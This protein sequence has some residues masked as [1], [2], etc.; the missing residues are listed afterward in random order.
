MYVFIMS[1][2]IEMTPSFEMF[3][4]SDLKVV[5]GVGEEGWVLSDRQITVE[6]PYTVH[7][8]QER[9]HSILVYIIYFFHSFWTGEGMNV[10]E[11]TP[12]R[13]CQ[14]ERTWRRAVVRIGHELLSYRY[15][16]IP[17]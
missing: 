12:S 16:S 10:V 9:E 11:R 5:V 14:A 8:Q 2:K 3:L 17:Q 15:A 1:T 7:R 13:S 6:L 4:R